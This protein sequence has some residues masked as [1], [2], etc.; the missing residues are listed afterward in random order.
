M[1][2]GDG[3]VHLERPSGGRGWQGDGEDGHDAGITR[4]HRG[5]ATPLRG[6]VVVLGLLHSDPPSHRDHTCKT[7]SSGGNVTPGWM[8]PGTASLRPGSPPPP[9]AR[10]HDDP[11]DR[12]R[13]GYPIRVMAGAVRPGT[14]LLDC[15]ED[16]D[17]HD[18][19]HGKSRQHHPLDR[20]S[21]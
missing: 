12:P 14:G 6:A 3:R 9:E 4:L 2:G 20:K 10:T 17:A 19:G 5:P 1:A 21:T 18:E 15:Q 13:N 7:R 11:G 8:A 16:A